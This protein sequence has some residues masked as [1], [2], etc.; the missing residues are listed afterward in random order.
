MLHLTIHLPDD[1]QTDL[2][3]LSH[4]NNKPLDAVITESL[5]HYLALISKSRGYKQSVIHRCNLNTL[6]HDTVVYAPYTY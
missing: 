4:R 6:V 3:W 1:L 5:R 2:E